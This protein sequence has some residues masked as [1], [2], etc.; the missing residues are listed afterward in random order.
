MTSTSEKYERKQQGNLLL[1]MSV[2]A[3]RDIRK[4]LENLQ[5]KIERFADW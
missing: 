5:K 2:E 4:I 3:D 1:E